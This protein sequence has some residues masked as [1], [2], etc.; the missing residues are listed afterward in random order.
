MEGNTSSRFSAR[1]LIRVRGYRRL[2]RAWSCRGPDRLSRRQVCSI[3]LVGGGFGRPPQ[4]KRS[5]LARP[6]GQLAG[7]LAE[8]YIHPSPSRQIPMSYQHAI[9][10]GLTGMLLSCAP[11]APP[12]IS[13]ADQAAIRTNLDTYTKNGLAGDWDAWGMTLAPDV[14]YMPPNMSPLM[15]REAA[16][17][18]GRGFP[19]LTSLSIEPLE[20]DG[21]ADIA[22]VRGRF[23]YSVTMPDGSAGGDTGSFL[24]VFR[25]QADGS[26][27][28][29]QLIWH[30]DTPAPAP[31]PATKQ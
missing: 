15:G 9:V 3:Q 8:P 2:T 19:K 29:A 14:V 27:L 25:R 31:P 12:A 6:G 28:A 20:I 1:E 17:T 22:Y 24:D 30:S 11:G 7:T 10:I 21:R 5:S 26:W 16:V 23:A 18:F 4:L 13:D